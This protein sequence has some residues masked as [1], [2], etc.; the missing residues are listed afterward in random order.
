MNDYDN[1][2]EADYRFSRS[3]YYSI[4]E[5]GEDALEELIEVAKATEHPRSYEVLAGMLK[6]LADVN[7]SLMD[8]HKKKVTME[9]DARLLTGEEHGGV[10]NNNLFVG[11]T[12]DLQ[13]MLIKQHEEEKLIEVEATSPESPPEE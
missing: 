13:R 9:K 11:S 5:K 7:G 4:L 2:K 6:N 10:T 1:D 3:M 8:L 12:T